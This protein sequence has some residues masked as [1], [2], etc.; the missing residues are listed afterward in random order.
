[1]K[2]LAKYLGGSHLYGLN[3]AKSDLDYRVVFAHTDP[4]KIF[5]FY[6]QD[7]F[8]KQTEEVDIQETELVHFLR[9]VEK[10][11]THALECLFAPI[12][13]FTYIDLFFRN[14]IINQRTRLLD[15][16]KIYK[17]LR[18]YVKGEYSL[19]TGERSGR[20]GGKRKE[21]L[22]QNGFSP[23]NFSHLFRLLAVGQ[24]YFETGEYLVR[25]RDKSQELH[26]LCFELKVNPENFKIE[27][28]TEKFQ[29]EN[30]KFEDSHANSSKEI[31]D[32]KFDLEYVGEVLMT[33]YTS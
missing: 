3:H 30:Q 13:C 6:Q 5:R 28:L 31:L 15:S 8:V 4:I 20:L 23:K 19:A 14:Q 10:G 29:E 11:G 16:E 2:I 32:R 7:T 21:A 27:W 24:H 25:P 18:G 9:Q 12:D 1:M 26:D 22:E 33:T 17:S